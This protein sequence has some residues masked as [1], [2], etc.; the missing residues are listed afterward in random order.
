MIELSQEICEG[1]RILRPKGRLDSHT[2]KS[3]EEQ[4][5]ALVDK[6]PKK[7]VIDFSDVDYISSAGL[8]T[9]LVIAQHAKSGSGKLTFC[10]ADANVSNLF[11]VCGF[12]TVF[13]IYP[14]VKEAKAA[15]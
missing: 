1:V 2:A 4:A 8:R 5:T 12:D 10:A 6:G 13:G 11:Q 15:L 14:T 7:V 9:L 3:F